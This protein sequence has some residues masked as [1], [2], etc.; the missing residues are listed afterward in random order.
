MTLEYRLSRP[1]HSRLI[2]VRVVH[3]AQL[4]DFWLI[5]PKAVALRQVDSWAISMFQEGS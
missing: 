4:T 1:R 3:F 5:E 2:I